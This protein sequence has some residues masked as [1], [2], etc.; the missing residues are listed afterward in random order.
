VQTGQVGLA[1]RRIRPLCHLSGGW[2][3][4][5]YHAV[6]VPLSHV[7]VTRA[8]QLGNSLFHL[9]HRRDDVRIERFYVTLLCHVWRGVSKSSDETGRQK[10]ELAVSRGLLVQSRQ[11]MNSIVDLVPSV[12]SRVPTFAPR[13]QVLSSPKINSRNSKPAPENLG[14]SPSGAAMFCWSTRQV[15]CR[16]M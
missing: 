6:L 5:V 2:F 1:N 14:V 9:L 8:F 12:C 7:C 4:I 16:L 3:S 15:F 11:F 10:F 13:L